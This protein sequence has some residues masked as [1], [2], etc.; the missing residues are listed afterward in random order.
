MIGYR[1]TPGP[2]V[3]FPDNALSKVIN[4]L[5]ENK[6]SYRV[7]KKGQFEKE[8]NYKKINQY[9]KFMNVAR[10]TALLKNRL[11]ILMKTIKTSN[12]ETLERVIE[13]IEECLRL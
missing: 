10:K 11:D 8:Y 13:S 3:G 6:I 12:K 2:K 9:A 5:E 7:I 4:R 1:V